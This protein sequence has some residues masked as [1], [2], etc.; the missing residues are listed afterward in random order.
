MH[1]DIGS[2]FYCF[3]SLLQEFIYAYHGRFITNTIAAFIGVQLPL[4]LNIHPIEWLHSGAILFKS[5]FIFI[6]CVLLS[7][8]LFIFRKDRGNLSFF[9]YFYIITSTLLFYFLYQ[10]AFLKTYQSVLYM[11]FYGFTFPFIVYFI[12]WNFLISQYVYDYNKSNKSIF[13]LCIL[14][15]LIGYSSE[16]FSFSTFA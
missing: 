13:I 5:F 12:F 10:N 3:N 14:S 11:S 16:F 2:M 15:F 9:E 1:D 8:N 4:A 6:I 7:S